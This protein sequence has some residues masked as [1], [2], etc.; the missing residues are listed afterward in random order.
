MINSGYSEML[1]FSE[2]QLVDCLYVST[3]HDGCEGGGEDS[4]FIYLQDHDIQLEADYGYVSGDTGTWGS[5]QYDA[6]PM[7][8]IRT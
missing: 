2:Q 5:C 8:G 6:K 7:T 3:G 4:A 1:S